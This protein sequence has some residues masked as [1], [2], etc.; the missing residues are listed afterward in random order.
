M[1]VHEYNENFVSQ[2]WKTTPD[3]LQSIKIHQALS[4]D[5]AK[6]SETRSFEMMSTREIVV[7]INKLKTKNKRKNGK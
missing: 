7:K 3:R 4:E 6:Q 1:K 2:N 5:E